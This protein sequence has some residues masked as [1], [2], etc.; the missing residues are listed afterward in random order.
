VASPARPIRGSPAHPWQTQNGKRTILKTWS[1]TALVQLQSKE[2]WRRPIDR[3][4]TGFGDGHFCR[5]SQLKLIAS[6]R[7]K[8]QPHLSR[9]I[10]AQALQIQLVAQPR[11]LPAVD[12]WVFEL[13]IHLHNR[14]LLVVELLEQNGRLQRLRHPSKAPKKH[15]SL[16]FS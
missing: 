12:F 15:G 9:R 14:D 11:I 7:R 3:L 13:R 6:F 4:P 1:E 2:F 5:R 8:M 16:P 10:V